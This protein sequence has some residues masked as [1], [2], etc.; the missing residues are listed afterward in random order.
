MRRELIIDGVSI[1]LSSDINI[2]VNKTIKDVQQPDKAKSDYTKTITL[3][4]SKDLDKLLTFI[5]EINAEGTFNPNKKVNAS[6]LENSI[7][8]ISGYF[9]L[10]EIIHVDKER[11]YKGVLFGEVANF[12]TD[13]TDKY[14]TDIEDLDDFN[15]DYTAFNQVN[16]WDT[17]IIK[18]GTSQT[19][20]LGSGYVY[21][22]INYGFDNSLNS[23]T[24]TDLFPA[25]Y[26]KELFDR[27]FKDVGYTYDSS[28]LTGSLRF[29]REI[30]PFTGLDFAL[31][32]SQIQNRV[33]KNDTASS[34]DSLTNISDNGYFDI[35]YT[36]SIQDLGS[37]YNSTLGE[38]T[39]SNKGRYTV[40]AN[41]QLRMTFTP[42][43][44]TVPVK[45]NFYQKCIL[46]IRKNGVV[47]ALSD[48]NIHPTL[49]TYINSGDSY[50]TASS[51]TYPSTEYSS[52][53]TTTGTAIANQKTTPNNI[54]TVLQDVVLNSGDVITTE[55]QTSAMYIDSGFSGKKFLDASNNGFDGKTD[56]WFE[57]GSLENKVVNT[58][59]MEGDTLDMSQAV[60]NNVKQT[61]FITSILKQFNLYL[62]PKADNPKELLI[63]PRDDFYTSDVLDWSSKLDVS[64]ELIY[65]PMGLLDA[66]KYIYSYD[67]DKDYYNS[68]YLSQYNRTYGDAQIDIDND[69]I[70]STNSNVLAFA[71][72]PIVGQDFNDL[73]VPSILKVDDNGDAGRVE[74]KM[75][76]LVY[77]GLI[78]TDTTWEHSGTVYTQYPYCG[79][80]DN[81]FNPTFDNNFDLPKEIYY[82]SSFH[83]IT[84]TDDNL[85]NRY[86][87]KGLEE[88]TDKNSK[89]VTG[90]FNLTPFDIYNLDFRKQYRFKNAYFRLQKVIDY[91]GNKGELTKCEFLK[92]KVKDVFTPTTGEVYGGGDTSLGSSSM[93]LINTSLSGMADNNSYNTKTQTVGGQDNIIDRSSKNVSVVGV[94]NV[95]GAN[96]KNITISGSNNI[97]QA[98][99]ENVQLINTSDVE[100]TE[101]NVSYINGQSNTTTYLYNEG[102]HV[103]LPTESKNI[104]C[105]SSSGVIDVDLPTAVGQLNEYNI[106]SVTGDYDVALYAQTSETIDNSS[107][108]ILTAEEWITIFSDGQKWLIK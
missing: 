52:A 26:K 40:I 74:G 43:D 36:N 80:F 95:I 25:F 83:T 57:S 16:S 7:S 81:P 39:V 47:V 19:F 21:P 58:S 90:Y 59:V 46:V 99:L 100:I 48:V 12:F 22:L 56:V 32:D 68:L 96:T 79:H 28:F 73:V 86:H 78:D 93:P 75:R 54:R 91:N 38:Y 65:S 72:T 13:I 5:F 104:I 98:G 31:T 107:T 60:P 18:N 50:N 64:K 24:T 101:S 44:N 71:S 29:K 6:Y 34:L 108:L 77:G 27:I 76:T 9:Q 4:S 92:L 106:Y 30:I 82:D 8:I 17:S 103:D 67:T 20:A 89:L 94:G 11:N 63:L 53:V 14:L 49:G 55:L 23:Y 102:K 1:P 70:S 10:K 42:T 41:L 105:D 85:Y 97:I 2:S 45:T 66:N 87:K 51:P 84:L 37:V 15:H 62:Q 3:P 33:F 88:I 61:D 69:F 35:T